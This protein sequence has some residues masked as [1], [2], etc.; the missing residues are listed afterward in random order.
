MTIEIK[1]LMKIAVDELQKEMHPD[2]FKKYKV[3]S[4]YNTLTK[5]DYEEFKME[6][7]SDLKAFFR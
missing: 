5:E 3:L 6:I 2:D 7:I 4:K 1:K